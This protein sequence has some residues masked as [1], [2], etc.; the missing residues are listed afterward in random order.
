MLA[1]L[2]ASNLSICFWI[3]SSSILEKSNS[4]SPIWCPVGIKSDV[5]AI[6]FQFNGVS[7]FRIRDNFAAVNGKNGSQRELKA[8]PICKATYI[9]VCTRS[10]FSLITFQGSSSA[11]YLFPKRATFINS[12]RASLNLYLSNELEITAG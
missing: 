7:I 4:A 8:A 6:V 2:V 3:S 10:G 1:V 11:K 12:P 9:C 5:S